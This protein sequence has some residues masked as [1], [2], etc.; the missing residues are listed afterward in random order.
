MADPQPAKLSVPEIVNG[1]LQTALDTHRRDTAETFR[2]VL[3]RRKARKSKEAA[4]KSKRPV[5][6]TT[7]TRTIKLKGTPHVEYVQ[8][9]VKK[10]DTVVAQYNYF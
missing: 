6:L 9:N 7:T 8:T 5:T 4:A 1:L 3:E 10:G 2:K